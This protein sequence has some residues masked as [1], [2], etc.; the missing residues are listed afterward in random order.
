VVRNWIIIGVWD[1]YR[2]DGKVAFFLLLVDTFSDTMC[3]YRLDINK[4]LKNPSHAMRPDSKRLP[5][6]I[7]RHLVTQ[8]LETSLLLPLAFLFL[9]QIPSHLLHMAHKKAPIPIISPHQH[10]QRLCIT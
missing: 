5:C 7:P 4:V 3:R 10:T 2:L 9:F 1:I 6:K 8:C